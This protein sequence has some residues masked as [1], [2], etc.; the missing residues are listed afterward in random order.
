VRSLIA[1]WTGPG[2]D[3]HTR[4][5]KLARQRLHEADHSALGGAVV[6]HLRLADHAIVRGGADHAAVWAALQRRDGGPH[7]V[8]HAVEVHTQHAIPVRRIHLRDGDV[9]ADPGVRHD[10]VE[11]APAGEDALHG[12]VHGARV[13]HVGG[14]PLRFVAPRGGLLAD[15]GETLRQ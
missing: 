15:A 14:D 4:G 10:H 6:R 3:R 13:G 7:R 5:T 8:E 2:V 12:T 9:A 1:V 11:R